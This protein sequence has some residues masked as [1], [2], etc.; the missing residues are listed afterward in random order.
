LRPG[1][2]FA[3]KKKLQVSEPAEN[4]GH[5]QECQAGNDQ[6]SADR[7]AAAI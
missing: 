2:V 7:F 3:V 5:P 1:Q 4:G 6:Q